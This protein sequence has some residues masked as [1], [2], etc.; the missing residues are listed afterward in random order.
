MEPIPKV[1]SNV[2]RESGWVSSPIALWDCFALLMLVI[3]RLCKTVDQK[4]AHNS[5]Q[6]RPSPKRPIGVLFEDRAEQN[7]R[8]CRDR[9]GLGSKQGSF[10]DFKEVTSDVTDMHSTLFSPVMF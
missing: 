1:H 2:A 10:G 6:H 9:R 7:L 4:S 8:M 3:T 5:I